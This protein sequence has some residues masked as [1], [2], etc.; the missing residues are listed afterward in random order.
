MKQRA[1]LIGSFGVTVLAIAAVFSLAGV[2]LVSGDD[3]GA[4]GPTQGQQIRFVDPAKVAYVI[5]YY[6]TP[7]A[8]VG[9]GT[10]AEPE[11]RRSGYSYGQVTPPTRIAPWNSPMRVYHGGLPRPPT[12]WDRESDSGGATF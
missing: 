2:G 4:S 11:H 7:P 10:E 12:P 9:S 5:F 3:G 6:G 8:I 1:V